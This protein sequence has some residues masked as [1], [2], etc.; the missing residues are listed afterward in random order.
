MNI[1]DIIFIIFIILGI[2]IGFKRGFISTLGRIL[3]VVLGIFMA[4]KYSR[5]L[6]AYNEDAFGIISYFSSFFD[7]KLSLPV[8]FPNDPIVNLFITNQNISFLQDGAMYL[9]YLIT[10]LLCFLLIFLI[11]SK[12]SLFILSLL[13]NLINYSILGFFNRLAGM[14]F[15][16]LKNF[17]IIV[18]ILGF[19]YP[20]IKLA[21]NMGI[22]TASSA[23]NAIQ[24]SMLSPILL[25]TFTNLSELVGIWV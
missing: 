24:N 7:E 16:G 11:V 23:K 22:E 1:L 3:S 25:E 5:E 21:A 19:S 20:A 6:A 13:N 10:I 18:V 9:A 2:F 8:L 12:I 15:G 14:F 17:I 4:I